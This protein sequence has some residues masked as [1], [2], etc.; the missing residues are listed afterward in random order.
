MIAVGEK[1]PEFTGKLGNGKDLSLKDFRGKKNVILYFFPKDFTPGC[2]KEACSFRDRR[3]DIAKLDAEIVGASFDTATKHKE[4][5]EAY[6]LPYPLVSDPDARI[7]QAYGVGHL[8]G[9]LG[10]WLPTKRVTFVIDKDGVVRHVIKSELNID[11]HID[12]AI[13]ALKR[14]QK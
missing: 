4:F 9:L 5:A 7:A 2:T 3:P 1:A 10:G 13:D 8:G 14:L 11:K 12:E 6:Q